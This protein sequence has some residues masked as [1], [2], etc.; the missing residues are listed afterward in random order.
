VKVLDAIPH[1]L[2]ARGHN[3]CTPIQCDYGE[4]FLFGLSDGVIFD[5][6]LNNDTVSV[7]RL[8]CKMAQQMPSASPVAHNG[9][10]K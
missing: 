6:D 8:T 2:N 10:A 5:G 7:K 3:Q 9:Q 4:T 1:Q